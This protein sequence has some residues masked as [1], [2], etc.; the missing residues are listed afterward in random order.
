MMS[1]SISVTS[2]GIGHGS[3]FSILFPIVQYISIPSRESPLRSPS[4]S[5]I[6]PQRILLTEDNKSTALVMTRFLKKL[7]HDVKTAYC[8]KEGK[9]I[10]RKFLIVAMEIAANHK[11]DLV[12]SDVGLPDGSGFDLMKSLSSIYGLRGN[13]LG[14]ELRIILGVCVTGYGMEDD[15]KQSKECGF[16]IH[17]VK[18]VELQALQSALAFVVRQIQAKNA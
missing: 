17:I 18:P 8:I 13:A 5:A 4:D 15:I 2:D 9:E 16:D 7:G 14:K 11:F 3:V 1:G 6:P 12:V 10:S